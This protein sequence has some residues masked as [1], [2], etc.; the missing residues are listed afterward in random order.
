MKNGKT[1][2]IIPAYNAQSYIERAIES[3]LRQTYDDIEIIIINDGSTDKTS[4]IIEEYS[5]KHTNI[6]V[7]STD[8]GGVSRARNIGID[9]SSGEYI[10]FLDADDEL[11]P[12]SVENM[13]ECLIEADAD[14]VNPA[15]LLKTNSRIYQMSGES[16]LINCINDHPIGYSIRKLYK[17]SFIEDIRFTE[18]KAI[19]EDSFFNFLCALKKPRVLHLNEDAYK[20]YPTPNSASRSAF[21][22][23][24]FDI[25]YFAKRKIEII[26]QYYPQYN[27]K[28]INLQIKANLALLYK[29]CS[30]R[31]KGYTKIERELIKYVIKNKKYFVPV[32]EFDKKWFSVVKG[33]RYFIYKFLY[34][35][36]NKKMI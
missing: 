24:Y 35:L 17:R 26:N 3:A 34:K 1:S 9:N 12:Y 30:G 28:M 4:E 22:E 27:D 16:Y 29:M 31:A 20:V 18:G 32:I 19:H 10:V 5:Q 7:I 8:N 6:K 15:K 36:K 11:L 33:R 14:I 23:K 13:V 2:I 25:L 21:S